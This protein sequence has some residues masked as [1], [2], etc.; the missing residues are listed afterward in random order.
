MKSF[1][2]RRRR[3]SLVILM[4]TI[5]QTTIALQTIFAQ[6]VKNGSKDHYLSE[7]TVYQIAD[8][9]PEFKGGKEA[10]NEYFARSLNQPAGSQ[11]GMTKASAYISLVIEKDGTIS[12][13]KIIKGISPSI[14]SSILH[15]LRNMPPWNP[16]MRNNEPVSVAIVLPVEYRR[17]GNESETE[18]GND[19]EIV[20]Y[21]RTFAGPEVA[22]PE[23]NYDNSAGGDMVYTIVEELPAFPGGEDARIR[24]LAN[25]IIYPAEA[26]N[27]GIQGTVY[28]T[29][30]IEKDGSVSNAGILRG[31]HPAIDREAVRVIE[32]MPAWK[33]GKQN[34]KPVRVRINTPIRFTISNSNYRF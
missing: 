17:A 3:T 8:P 12:N 23:K 18:N 28:V 30:I 2:D 11:S 5:L 25:N 34:G 29:Y 7:E 22:V 16:G 13:E 1:I 21:S 20:T 6:N 33:P 14:D 19:R 31:I 24:F 15:T 4:I 26:G 10:L 27:S 32:S 9:M